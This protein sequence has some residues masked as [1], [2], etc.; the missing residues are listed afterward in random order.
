MNNF[1]FGLVFALLCWV[2]YAVF[3][4]RKK[5]VKDVELVEDDKEEALAKLGVS[6][7][8]SKTTAACPALMVIDGGAV[9]KIIYYENE[10]GD[11]IIEILKKIS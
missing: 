10:R 11:I 1:F 7:G 5:R 6:G 9:E 4:W 3:V 8:C 2:N